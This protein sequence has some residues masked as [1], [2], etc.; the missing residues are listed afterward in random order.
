LAYLENPARG[1]LKISFGYVN[2]GETKPSYT[3]KATK[4]AAKVC[5]VLES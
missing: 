4:T 3:R 1:Y 5:L 2:R